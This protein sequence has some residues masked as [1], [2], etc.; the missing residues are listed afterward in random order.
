ML[1]Q[2]AGLASVVEDTSELQPLSSEQGFCT[3]ARTPVL[4]KS[5]SSCQLD[6]HQHSLIARGLSSPNLSARASPEASP[7][8]SPKA[9]PKRKAQAIIMQVRLMLSILTAV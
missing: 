4:R 6:R 9:Q 8:H 1:A 7:P 5:Q 2:K 3:P